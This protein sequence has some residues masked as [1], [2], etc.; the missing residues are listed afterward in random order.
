MERLNSHKFAFLI[1]F[2]FFISSTSPLISAQESTT[3]SSTIHTNWLGE[4]NHGYLLKFNRAPSA[5]ELG[6][7]V[8]NSTHMISE[9]SLSS[10]L[11]HSWGDG[12][13]IIE[14]NVFS[15][16]L[17][18]SIS[19]GDQ[20]EIKVFLNNVIIA[21]RVFNP[22]IWTQPLAD[23]EV[24][25][26]THWEL[27]QT[28]TSVQGQDNYVLIFDGQGWQ[29]RTDSTLEANELGNGT[30]LL[31]ES[32]QE[33]NILFDLNLDSV[34][35]NET[36][37][38]GVL[39]D[40]E[41]E[42]KGNGSVSIFDNTEGELYVNITVLDALI[43]RSMTSEIISEEFSIT[44]FGVMNMHDEED[45]SITDL[46][47]EI[48]FF[49]LE[50]YDENGQRIK[51]YND[52]V[53]TA[54]MEQHYDSN[55]IYLEVNELRFFESWLHGERIA[56]NNLISAQGTF[57]IYE[58]KEDNDRNETEED[59]DQGTTI[60][61]T[62]V[63]FETESIDGITIEDYMHVYG[64]ISGDTEGTWGL[65]RE[66]EDS[67]PSANSSGDL[68]TVNVIHNQVWYNITGA[69]GFFADEIGVGAYHNQTWD[70][71]AMPIDWE[72]RT[73]RY[74]W[75]T[76]GADPSEGEEYP[77]RSPQQLEPNPPVAESQLGNISVSRETGYSPEFLLPG[78]IVTLDQGG[79]FSLEIEATEIGTISRDGHDM[80]VTYWKTI[81][82]FNSEG[83][84]SGSVINSGL[85]A[86]LLAEVSRE[87]IID[88]D[89]GEA[90]FSEYQTLERILSPS[91]VTEE[92]NNPPEI[93]DVK[94]R[95]GI[96]LND[97]GNI[98]H[99]E[100]VVLD[101]DWNVNDVNVEISLEEYKLEKIELNDR[102]L[103][104]DLAIQ[105][106]IW[107]TVISWPSESH[108][109]LEIIVEVNDLFVTSTE[110]WNLNISNMAPILIE[111]SLDAA[112]SSRSS[113]VEII[114][115]AI[116]ANG[117]AGISVDLR[118]DGGDLYV[119]EY[120]SDFDLWQGDFIIP[121]TLVP[122][123]FTV[124]LLLVDSDGAQ[125]IVAGPSLLVTNEGPIMINSK[126]NPEK[127]IAPKL[128]TM[129][130]EEY[131][132]SV[133]ASDPD[134]ISA[135]QI[136]FHEL[137]PANEGES[138]KLMYD[139]GSNGDLIPGDGVYSLSFQARHLPAGFVEIEL[140]GIDIYGQST[141]IKQNINIESEDANL[142]TDP[143]KGVVELLSNPLV[144]FS[145]LFVLVG[146]VVVAVLMLKKNG[147]NF[148]NFGE[149]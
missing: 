84:A 149:D 87:I 109:E 82:D 81:N 32:N 101:P 108:G 139:D 62:I 14:L 21:S 70:Y 18:D 64:T 7:I 97:A 65:F 100:I 68:F 130:E 13:G 114:A 123:L 128:G 119:L 78:D 44:G 29:K 3:L 20:V 89:F 61:G 38:D 30:L 115:K 40:S 10:Q 5:E 76:T 31:N 77:E 140:R 92:E 137:F 59:T 146:V 24:T 36:T 117:V 41:F 52:I 147:I 83:T 132:V 86:G 57:D 80:P 34:W 93:L 112:Q 96:L 90:L 35:R 8:V 9:Q 79:L 113:S 98:A 127:I 67:G 28:S 111:S 136:K 141:I 131:V 88:T 138:W 63:H 110:V 11:N 126:I 125:N 142:G 129:S 91:I 124:P 106:D 26:S 107:T 47:G 145:L 50:Y 95:E 56:E 121:N 75:R 45:D 134:G 1:V 27:D 46:N 85:L 99:L 118:L 104:G 53:A 49:K 60:N 143:S 71:Q 133:E 73:I 69:A 6:G 37:I 74:A 72:N 39:S 2:C 48:S 58:E 19:Y 148:G 144:I 120:I 55:H 102:G 15:I 25:L 23:H 12:L 51:N 43:N 4:N 135:V 22:V 116:D 122:G 105:D 16:I 54:E 42:M 33:G 103:N 66:I 94:F 17:S